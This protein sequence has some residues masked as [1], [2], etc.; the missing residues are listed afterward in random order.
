MNTETDCRREYDRSVIANAKAEFDRRYGASTD[1]DG[2]KTLTG[3]FDVTFPS[4][5]PGQ[6]RTTTAES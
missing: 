5:D 3:S 4:D 1:S 2:N 6:L